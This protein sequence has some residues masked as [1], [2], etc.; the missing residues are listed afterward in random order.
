MIPRLLGLLI[1]ICLL[2]TTTFA[3]ATNES[4]YQYGYLS[5][6]QTAPDS[7]PHTNS[8]QDSDNCGLTNASVYWN[9]DGIIP[10]VTNTTACHNG[11]VVGWKIWCT[12]NAVDCVGNLT[13]GYFP[14]FFLKIHHWMVQ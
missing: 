6:S 4:S 3:K 9:N 1:F 13:S 10:A 7:D 14:D 11:F 5:G 2:T 12:N 8:Y